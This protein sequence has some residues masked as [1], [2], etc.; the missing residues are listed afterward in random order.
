MS[1]LLGMTGGLPE[2]ANS[3]GESAHDPRYVKHECERFCMRG[4][5]ADAIGSLMNATPS[6]PEHQPEQPHQQPHQQQQQPVTPYNGATPAATAGGNHNGM[7][8]VFSIF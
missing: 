6:Q 7:V 3:N 4:P 5:A 1:Q 2:G 8:S